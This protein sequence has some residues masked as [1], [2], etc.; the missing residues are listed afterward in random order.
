MIVGIDLGVNLGWVRGNAVGP[1][2][3]G[4]ISVQGGSNYGH[5]LSSSVDA[6]HHIL[7]DASAVAVEQPFMGQDYYPARKLLGQLG[8]LHLMARQQGISHKAIEEIPIATGKLTLSGSGRADGPRMIAAAAERG[9]E[10]NEHEAHALGI[11]WVYVFGKR[12]PVG[13][14]PRS[15]KGRSVLKEEA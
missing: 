5:F 1:I 9:L 13:K 15:S 6:F 10:M 14:R 11:W 4:T 3:Y 7:R 12:E 8:L 2:E